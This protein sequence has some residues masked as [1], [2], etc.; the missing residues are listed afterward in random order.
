MARPVDAAR[1]AAGAGG[2]GAQGAGAPLDC[3]RARHT[4]ARAPRRAPAALALT[5]APLAARAHSRARARAAARTA[6]A[7][8]V[9]C[10]VGLYWLLGAVG[11]ALA[12][13]AGA[14][15]PAA[16][17]PPALAGARAQAACALLYA[18]LCYWRLCA[19]VRAFVD[20][21]RLLPDEYAP[22]HGGAQP[23]C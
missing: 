17:L 14:R 13:R 6:Q 15:Y 3:A 11:S 16:V 12:E 22:G 7:T 2:L 1:R 21:P 5:R 4:R 19:C 8:Y 9:L 23:V 10:C 18:L 20:M